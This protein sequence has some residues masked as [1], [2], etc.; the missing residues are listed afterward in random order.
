MYAVEFE[1]DVDDGII[2]IPEQH[3]EL[4]GK[5]VKVILMWE[6]PTNVDL[7]SD[8]ILKMTFLSRDLDRKLTVGNYLAKLFKKVWLEGEEFNGKRPFGN[9]DWQD[10]VFSALVENGIVADEKEAAKLVLGLIDQV[11]GA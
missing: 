9:S 1:A 8:D 4:W 11:C 10:D 7:P 2:E 3:R 5:H 6:E